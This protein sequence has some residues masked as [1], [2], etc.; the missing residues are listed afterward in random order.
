M[1]MFA[2]GLLLLAQQGGQATVGEAPALEIQQGQAIQVLEAAALE[3]L[4]GED[5]LVDLGQEPAVDAGQLVDLLNTHPQA[6]G[7]AHVPDAIRT[8]GHQLLAHQHL[9]VR[10]VQIHHGVKA[11]GTGLKTPQGLLEGLLEA[12]PDG[13]HLAHRLHLGGELGLGLGNFSK[14]KRG[15]LVTT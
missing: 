7:I 4:F 12:A 6:E 9:R 5:Q 1:A 13:H 14:V 15:T 11:V 3:L 8:V 10:V 2:H